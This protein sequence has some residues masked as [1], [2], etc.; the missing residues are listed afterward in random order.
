MSKEM[1]LGCDLYCGEGWGNA[2]GARRLRSTPDG[3]TF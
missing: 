1:M 3:G 2:D